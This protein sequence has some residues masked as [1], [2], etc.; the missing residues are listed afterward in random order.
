[1]HAAAIVI[2]IWLV[3][4]LLYVIPPFDN[5]KIRR[6]GKPLKQPPNTL[7]IAGNG[8]LFLQARHKLFA[9]FVKC[10]K[11]FGFET[12]QISVP[13]LPPGVVINDP[14]N[15][16]YVL[17]NEGIFAKGDF[18][19]RRSWDLFGNGIINSDGELWKVQR[20]AGLHFLNTANLKVLTDVALPKYLNES[21]GKLHEITQDAIV[22][23]EAVFLEVTTQLM[24]RM[25]Y[26]VTSTLTQHDHS[27]AYKLI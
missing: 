5:S 21:V 26:N 25:A 3:S 22:D 23:L 14:K 9:W 2:A 11:Q 24:G 16:E 13:T 12:F 8:I 7:P 18:F 17:K 27:S 20:K 4:L 15:L 1:M 6:D 10:E 19:K